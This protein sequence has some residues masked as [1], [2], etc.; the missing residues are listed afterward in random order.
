MPTA[1]ASQSAKQETEPTAPAAANPGA[2]AFGRRMQAVG[3]SVARKE[4]PNKV[5]GRAR[6][7][8]DVTPV[9]TLTACI[10]PSGHAHAQLVRVDVDSARRMPGVVAILT[11][12]DT[13]LL[14]GEVLEDRPPLARGTVRY[15]G[16]PVA[17][18]IAHGEAE[19]RAA[20]RRVAIQYAALPLVATVEAAVASDAPLIHP[21]LGTYTRAQPPVV[22]QAHTNIADHA[23]VRRGNPTEGWAASDVVV[24]GHYSVPQVD[25]AA[26]ETRSARVEILHD[27][28]VIVQS[29]T[30]A[31]FE[32]QKLLAKSFQLQQGQ[33]IVDVPLVGGAFGGKAAVQLEVLAYLASRAVGGRPVQ[34]VNSREED[35][36]TS[37][38]G[39]GLVAD[40]KLGATRDGQLQVADLTF[41][42][43]TGAYT[44]STPRVARAICSECT[45]P[46]RV[47][48]VR[49]DAYTVYTNHTYAT[50]FRGFGHFP[51]TFAIERT[52][53]RLAQALGMDPVALRRKNLIGPGDQTPTRMVLTRSTLGDPQ[54][55]L[56]R[57]A[58][59]LGGPAAEATGSHTV[60]ARG[61][62]LFWKTSSSPP[63]AISGAVVTFNQD[64]SVN[65][66]TGTVE[67]GAGTKTTSAQIVAEQL[68]IDV[69]QVH[70]HT[71][72]NTK[73]DPEHWKTV[74]SM[75]T[76]MAG[77]AVMEA[78][79]DAKA[80][81]KS[82]AA[83]A[84]KC[85][86]GDL[87]VA[88]G[89]VFLT[90]DPNIYVTFSDV[91]HG[92]SYPGGDAVGGQ[93]IGRGSYIMRHL[94]LLDE[95]TG[96]G[97][98]GPS[99]TVGAQGVE[100]DLDRRTWRYR[101][102][103]AVTV[104]DAG[105]VINPAGARA[106]LQGGM[107][108]GIGLATR[109]GVLYDRDGQRLNSQLRSYKVMRAGE[110]PDA[111]GVEFVETPQ[112]DAPFGARALGE[113]GL[114]A[115]PAAVAAAVSH[116]I[117]QPVDHLPITPESL[118]QLSRTAAAQ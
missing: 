115:M 66:S 88:Q 5:T 78:A 32:V 103:R 31:P 77:R 104:V 33:V 24:A 97:H 67:V 69:E 101:V 53:D 4:A 36:A 10:V 68:G 111:Y 19:A 98:P 43:D 109:E 54:A 21:A 48:H 34:V 61:L 2:G 85:A 16:E 113:H 89:R 14:C 71:H 117:G 46:Y 84:L 38:V 8:G 73:V 108:M 60:R 112:I 44:D 114:L 100:I 96:E 49:C 99:F 79:E 51:L 23:K 9:G 83:I 37:P 110:Q 3:Q 95:A 29:T 6:Y 25:H 40:V 50:A 94:T 42:L 106:M 102:V 59:L 72:I 105:R 62:A 22:P 12:E 52:M 80:Q 82:V 86:P 7:R 70:I 26:M 87:S 15:H 39:I 57:A 116:A 74:A 28:R 92:Y 65:L 64:G 107:C 27:G 58:T 1:Q 63:N 93:I 56:D 81:L 47:E 11:G 76:F 55:C 91:A 90:A 45:G 35:M 13:D 41:L 17:L 75:S 30:Q 18:V 118:W 20:A